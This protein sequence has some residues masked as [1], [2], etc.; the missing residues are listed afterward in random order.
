MVELPEKS[1]KKRKAAPAQ[2]PARKKQTRAPGRPRKASQPRDAYDAFGEHDDEEE[3]DEMARQN[4]DFFESINRRVQQQPEEEATQPQEQ[5]SGEL[6]REQE[7]PENINED[8]RG[9][10]FE[11][12]SSNAR[13]STGK[14]RKGAKRM[15]ATYGAPG[16][17]EPRAKESVTFSNPTKPTRKVSRLPGNGKK[18]VSATGHSQPLTSTVSEADNAAKELFAHESEAS[19]LEAS[20][21][22]D[23]DDE[24]GHPLIDPQGVQASQQTRVEFASLLPADCIRLMVQAEFVDKD[25]EYDFLPN[26]GGEKE[27]NLWVRR[28]RE[29]IP[30]ALCRRVL[31]HLFD[32]WQRCSS[33]PQNDKPEEQ[34][35]YLQAQCEEMNSM[36]KAVRQSLERVRGLLDLEC[37]Y[38]SSLPRSR[39]KAKEALISLLRQ[40]LPMLLLLLK[41]T[42]I[43]LKNHEGTGATSGEEEESSR[44][45]LALIGMMKQIAE[46][47][48]SILGWI[49]GYYQSEADSAALEGTRQ[50]RDI[51]KQSSEELDLSRRSQVSKSQQKCL[52]K[53]VGQNFKF[54][55]ELDKAAEEIFDLENE[56]IRKAQAAQRDGRLRERQQRELQRRYDASRQQAQLHIE[57][58]ERMNELREKRAQ[59]QQGLLPRKDD[60]YRENGEWYYHEDDKLLKTLRKLGT[61]KP[62][63]LLALLPGRSVYDIEMR[64]LDLKGRVQQ[65]YLDSHVEPPLWCLLSPR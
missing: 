14:G 62:T 11:P 26:F 15:K 57:S 51:R 41:N 22:A 27:R 17:R 8:E 24:D 55:R 30:S 63:D 52:D 64:I 45:T 40:L 18:R 53:V 23:Q 13:P 35:D 59:Q 16:Y 50:Q 3:D 9:E 43:S 42:M 34:A 6:A 5:S 28:H 12:R 10:A 65:H 36:A 37:G 19:D 60:Y 20:L 2:G 25:W 47:S 38:D 46:W 31:P 49:K 44:F 39:K 32:L 1:S 33:I 56:P 54:I 61:P 48:Q 4:P 29:E 7:D 58:L 21:A